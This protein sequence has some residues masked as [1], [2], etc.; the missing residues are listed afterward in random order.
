[1]S[2]RPRTKSALLWGAIG[3]FSFLVVLQTYRLLVGPLSFGV[4]GSLG[5]GVVVGVVVSGV[6]YATERRI[7]EKGRT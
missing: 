2:V 7:A 4:L 6:T 1:M 3:C 5:V